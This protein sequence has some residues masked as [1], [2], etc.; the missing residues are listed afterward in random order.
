VNQTKTVAS[1]QEIANRLRRILRLAYLQSRRLVARHGLTVPQL[2]CLRALAGSPGLPP[3]ALAREIGLSRATLTGMLRR[4]EA[5]RLVTRS[6]SPL[7]RR[8]SLV[9]LTELGAAAM[10][11]VGSPL[12]S[13]FSRAWCRLS[14]SE[15]Q[16]LCRA[17]DT[18]ATL[19]TGES[20]IES[21]ASPGSRE[22]REAG[23][24]ADSDNRLLAF[25]PRGRT[26]LGK[27]HARHHGHGAESM[28]TPEKKRTLEP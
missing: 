23:D 26:T 12:G 6:P 9:H 3:T 1:E 24:S 25:P 4:L 15:K 8:S 7:D 22:L 14:S 20:P 2:L 19:M 21:S 28:T 16:E 11:P 18:L 10:A 17:L 13:R 5:R 27:D